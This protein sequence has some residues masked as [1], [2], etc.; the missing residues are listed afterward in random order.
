MEKPFRIYLNFGVISTTKKISNRDLLDMV[1][2][3][4]NGICDYYNITVYDTD[5][6]VVLTFAPHR[7]FN[8]CDNDIHSP[9]VRRARLVADALDVL[10]EHDKEGAVR[11]FFG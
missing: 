11:D 8:E 1:I 6:N 9:I 4:A 2:Q 5:D 10:C 3:H 7:Q